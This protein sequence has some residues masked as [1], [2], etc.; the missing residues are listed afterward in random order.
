MNAVF[1]VC[2]RCGAYNA[3]KQID[4]VHSTAICPTCGHAQPFRRLPLFLLSGASGTGKSTICLELLRDATTTQHFIVLDADILW[5]EEF[6]APAQ[7]PKYVDLWL[8]LCKN[9]H[10]SGRPV[11]LAG[12]GFGVPDTIQPCTEARYFS[13]IHYLALVCDADV[14]ATRLR[15]RPAWRDSAQDEFLEKQIEYNRWFQENAQ[16]YEPPIALLDTTRISRRAS[17]DRVAAWARHM[18]QTTDNAKSS[19]PNHEVSQQRKIGK[20]E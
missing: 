9:L 12:A 18:Q 19:S 8:R 6:H 4:R 17:A 10:Q 5:T 2:P 15:E 7:W 14:L 1:N 11:L 13:A 16:R 3:E 20:Q